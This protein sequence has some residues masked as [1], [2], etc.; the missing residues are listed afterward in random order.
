MSSKVSF[1][2]CIVAYTLFNESITAEK[3]FV[4]LSC[5][6][7]IQ[8]ALNIAIPL[9]ISQFAETKSSIKRIKKFLLAPEVNDA[10]S[11]N[12]YKNTTPTL[13][14]DGKEKRFDSYNAQTPNVRAVDL[15]VEVL[16]NQPILHNIN[17]HFGPG[18]YAVCGPVGSGKSTL[19]KAL[20]NDLIIVN[21]K[22]NVTGSCSYASQDPWLFPGTIRENILFGLPY[23]IERYN[24]VVSICGL[25][26]DFEI[27]PDADST[28]VNDRGLNLSKGQQARVNLARAIYKESDIYLLDSPL[29]A[30]D[31]TV[32]RQIFQNCVRGFLKKKVCIVV[33]H[34]IQF[35]KEANKIL[36]I[37]DGRLECQ[38][39]FDELCKKGVHFG[40]DTVEDHARDNE[41]E[42]DKEV[43]GS[44]DVEADEATKLLDDLSCQ[45]AATKLYTENK[46]EG[47][48][49]WS[50]YKSYFKLAGGWKTLPFLCI[51]S[52]LQQSFQSGFEYFITYW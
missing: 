49:E 2:I 21:G 38:G 37:K 43:N 8:H 40:N 10:D 27:L 33:M 26:R 22:L 29:S 16:K 7:G 17:L 12:I 20:L 6:G 44:S 47:K 30:L 35:L 28:L 52:L 51:L 39:T 32:S 18:L 45:K 34:Q 41:V 19:L 42:S 11:K 31:A 14:R 13:Y 15:S 48:V 36:L 1:Y 46:K 24:N 5:Y 3:A 25:K 23:D 4:V 9:G 50:V